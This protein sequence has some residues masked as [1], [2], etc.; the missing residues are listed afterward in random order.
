MIRAAHRRATPLGGGVD[1]SKALASPDVEDV[2]A[3]CNTPVFDEHDVAQ[4]ASD[5]AAIPG[6]VDP[7]RIGA[8]PDRAG[9][10]TSFSHLHGP[11]W[12]GSAI[13]LHPD[14]ITSGALLALP[15]RS[16]FW[17]PTSPPVARRTVRSAPHPF[18]TRRSRAPAHESGSCVRCRA[19]PRIAT[20]LQLPAARSGRPAL[21][22]HQAASRRCSRHR[23]TMSTI[24]ATAFRSPAGEPACQLT[25]RT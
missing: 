13:A 20:S 6:A 25:S 14:G 9:A 15:K 22:L 3:R 5:Q 16:R 4:H 11:P 1:R 18:V 7:G 19:G 2:L 12:A 8:L 21:S 24:S 23:S 10:G 17:D